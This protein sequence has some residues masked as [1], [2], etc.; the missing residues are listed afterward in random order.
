MSLYLGGAAAG[1]LALCVADA[2]GWRVRA[3]GVDVP[4]P[5]ALARRADGRVLYVAHEAGVSAFAIGADG[6][7]ALLARAVCGLVAPVALAVS[8]D[9]AWL[10]VAGREGTVVVL[11]LAA[12]GC[13]GGAASRVSVPGAGLAA[14]AV[15]PAGRF[16]LAADTAGHAVHVLRW[17]SPGHLV[18]HRRVPRPGDAPHGVVF[19]SE[20]PVVFLAN[21]EGISA[22]HWDSAAGHLVGAQALRPLPR[23]FAGVNRVA[24]MVLSPDGRFLFVANSGH[25][26]LATVAVQRR[27]GK[28]F[29]RRLDRLAQEVALLGQ[30]PD[31]GML[32]AAGA[33]VE[34][35]AVEGRYAMLAR[36]AVAAVGFSVRT[37]A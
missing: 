7:L 4:A 3:L 18:V 20:I 11:P 12:D 24:G 36:R 28:M 37:V 8:A 30:S 1:E 25:D 34:G 19:H 22:C 31:G 14:L 26:S 9:D 6:G 17:A 13:V 10:L 5:Y 29:L 33:W 15:E 2:D 16:V 27:K 35:I 23:E 32:L 21:A